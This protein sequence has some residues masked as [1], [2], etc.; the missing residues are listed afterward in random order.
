MY[1]ELE[2]PEL[3]EP[4]L[5]AKDG[6]QPLWRGQA[7]GVRAGAAG[8]QRAAPQQALLRAGGPRRR[9]RALNNSVACY[10]FG[11]APVGARLWRWA[12]CIASVISAVYVYDAMTRFACPNGRGRRRL[13]TRNKAHFSCTSPPSC[14]FAVRLGRLRLLDELQAANRQSLQFISSYLHDGLRHGS[15]RI[16]SLFLRRHR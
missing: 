15:V 1:M 10:V 4:Q 13:K 6:V 7:R 3:P 2:L 11:N 12:W 16:R 8:H 5:R 14:Y 9:G